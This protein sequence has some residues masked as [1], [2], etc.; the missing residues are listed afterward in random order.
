MY[1]FRRKHIFY[2]LN[3]GFVSSPSPFVLHPAEATHCG[4]ADY[5]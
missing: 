3:L 5:R 4:D 2:F 1:R